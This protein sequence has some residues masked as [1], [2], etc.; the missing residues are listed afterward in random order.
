MPASQSQ[1]RIT[2]SSIWGHKKEHD[3]IFY[4]T[5]W[6]LAGLSFLTFYFL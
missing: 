2:T 4:E 5:V 3:Y 6:N 1:T